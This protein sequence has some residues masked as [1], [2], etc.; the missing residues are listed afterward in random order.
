MHTCTKC[1]VQKPNDKFYK[2][3]RFKN[4]L[5]RH[6]KACK[7]AYYEEN[8]EALLKKQRFRD[9]AK[10]IKKRPTTK[11]KGLSKY[12]YN[13]QYALANKE[14]IKEIQRRAKKRAYADP[15]KRLHLLARM[16]ANTAVKTGELVRENICLFCQEEGKTEFHHEDY[17]KPLE[18][19][20][21]CRS[22]HRDIHKAQTQQV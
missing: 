1:K 22:C 7:K 9:A 11:I 12:E 5:T 4:G 8:R 14:K 20:E 13:K 17:S 10:I 16:M 3:K 6:C 19:K 18:V 21:L 15:A 2:D